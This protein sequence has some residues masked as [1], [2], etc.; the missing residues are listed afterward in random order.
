MRKLP[1][2]VSE[3]WGSG[4]LKKFDATKGVTPNRQQNQQRMLPDSAFTKKQAEIKADDLSVKLHTVLIAQQS[5]SSLLPH[6]L[7]TCAWR[8][9]EE[10]SVEKT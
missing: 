10:A 8:G 1:L 7:R 6:R 2:L 4:D 9:K 5:T 3:G